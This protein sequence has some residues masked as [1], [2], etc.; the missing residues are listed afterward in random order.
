MYS[1]YLLLR[2]C[3][4]SSRVSILSSECPLREGPLYAFSTLLKGKF[5]SKKKNSSK[6]SDMEGVDFT[7]RGGLRLFW[8]IGR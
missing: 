7:N 5:S 8:S 1:Q 3:V 2:I 6:I 4:L